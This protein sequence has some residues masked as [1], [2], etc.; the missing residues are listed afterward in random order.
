MRDQKPKRS[1][2]L[3]KLLLIASLS[4]PSFAATP[5]LIEGVFWQPDRTT[6]NPF[7]AWDVIGANT[8][9]I[10]YAVTDGKSWYK[11]NHFKSWS[12]QNDW[13]RI[14][15]E[16]WS[17]NFIL[18]LAGSY[19]EPKGRAT[20]EELLRQSLI[21]I[22]ETK[23]LRP[24][25]YYFPVEVDPS[26]QN[27]EEYVNVVN[28]LPRPLWISVYSGDR[29]SRDITAW[30]STWLP[31]D[32]NVFFQDGVGVGVRRPE[33]AL[34]MYKQLQ[35]KLG[36]DRVA[37]ISEAFRER[38]FFSGFRSANFAELAEQMDTY[39][40][41]RIYIFDGPHYLGRFSTYFLKQKYSP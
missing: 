38:R 39:Q 6:A 16:P 26:W 2:F 32:V 37:L 3:T 5:S 27:L 33:Q 35:Q 20:L 17:R 28:Q 14:R 30:L 18:G 40:G 8:F 25:A 13:R 29:N 21:L 24:T 12:N 4:C 23:S 36:A 34:R 22:E 7:G 15:R 9:V 10:Q 1:L 41:E 11:S 19:D 31:E